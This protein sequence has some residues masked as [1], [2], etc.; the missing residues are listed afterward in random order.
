MEGK[1]AVFKL[2]IK[3]LNESDFPER[4]LTMNCVPVIQNPINLPN[5][6]N[7]ADSIPI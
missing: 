4:M 6:S 5:A 3:E 7:I 1:K 2:L